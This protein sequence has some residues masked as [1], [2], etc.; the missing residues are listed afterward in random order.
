MATCAN[1]GKELKE[2]AKFCVACGASAAA[3]EVEKTVETVA[4]AAVSVAEDTDKQ[5]KKAAREAEKA[6]KEAEKAAAEVQK[7]AERAA[8]AAEKAAEEAKKA[9]PVAAPQPVVPVQPAAQQIM[10]QPVMQQPMQT[11]QPIPPVAAQN[12]LPKKLRPLTTGQFMFTMFIMAIPVVGWLYTLIC[13]LLNGINRNRRNICRAA[14]Y[15]FL[16]GLLI[17]AILA[18]VGYFILWP[19]YGE[20]ILEWLRTYGVAV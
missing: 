11:Y 8:K 12:T 16:I 2:G 15:W 9:E 17:S 14:I 5:S 4:D 13:A 19:M 7:E 3:E 20:T 18:A 1:C 6:A 10:Q